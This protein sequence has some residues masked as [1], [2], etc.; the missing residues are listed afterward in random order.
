MSDEEYKTMFLSAE[1]EMVKKNG[2]E[3]TIKS[4]TDKGWR[5]KKLES[6][7]SK[8][9]MMQLGSRG[10]NHMVFL[11]RGIRDPNVNYTENAVRRAMEKSIRDMKESM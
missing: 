8:E 9:M 7:C 10:A 3:A 6:E 1:H 4:F 11:E 5:L 2:Y